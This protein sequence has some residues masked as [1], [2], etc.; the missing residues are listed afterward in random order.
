MFEFALRD[1]V[2]AHHPSANDDLLG[3]YRHQVGEAHDGRRHQ[4]RGDQR[5]DE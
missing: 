1:G 2:G 5:F 4:H 3:R